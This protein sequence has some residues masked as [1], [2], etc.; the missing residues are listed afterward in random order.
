MEH[1]IRKH[2]KVMLNTDPIYYKKISE[3]LDNILKRYKENWDEQ[4]KFM[5]L[6]REEIRQ[7]R[8]AEDGGLDPVRYA[9]FYDM[10]KEIAFYGHALVRDQ[11]E[12][13]KKVVIDVVDAISVEIAKVGFW[14]N[15]HKERRLRG[16]IDDSLI[17]SGVDS[18]IEHKEQVVSEFMKL[19][20][21]RTKELA[22]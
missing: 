17:Y 16:W 3:K 8:K 9:P 19:A 20:R 4:V 10:V 18:L 11:D 15:A 7:G 22:D 5:K 6:L 1:A 12:K 13:V 14:G 21:N 2:C